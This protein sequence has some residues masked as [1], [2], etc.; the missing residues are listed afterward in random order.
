ML[1]LQTAT[2]VDEQLKQFL[3]DSSGISDI[4]NET[5]IFASGIVNSLFAIQLIMFIEKTFDI[6][7][8]IADL[9]FENFSSINTITNFIESK[10]L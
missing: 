8:N 5:E 7:I 9:D 2:P 6:S 3:I 1:T 10:M 4:N